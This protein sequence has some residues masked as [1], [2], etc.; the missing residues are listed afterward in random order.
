MMMRKLKALL[1]ITAI[2]GLWIMAGLGRAQVGGDALEKGFVD[3]P[4][5]AKPRVW[6]HWT[7]GNVTKEGITKD[8]EWMKRVGVGGA[9]MADIGMAGGQTIEKKIEFFTPEWFDAIKHAAAESDRL[10]L[11]MSIF[12]SSGWSLTGGPW[13]KPEQAMKKL[14]W[15]ETDIEGPMTF[16]QKLQQPPSANGNF[17]SLRGR[18]TAGEQTAAGAYYGDSI[19]IAF[20]TP[21][22]ETLMEDSKPNVTTSG[23]AINPAPLMDDH[24]ATRA[25]ITAGSDDVAWV[26]YEFPQAINAKAVTLIAAGRGVPFGQI[27]AS[28]DGRSYRTIVELPGAVQYR[29]GGLKTYAFPETTAKFIRLRI[30]GEAPS[31]DAVMYQTAPKAAKQYQIAEFIVHTG[32]RVDRWEEKAGFNLLYDYQAAAPTP[33]FPSESMIQPAEV[34]DLSSKMDKG[35]MLNW[36]V[37][38]GKWTV[39]RMGYSLVGSK[40]RAGTAPGLGLEVDK[41][42][43]KH[44]EAYFHGYMDP[45]E[46]ALGPLMGKSLRYMMMDSW[47]AGMQNW[48]DD[49][50]DQF[51]KRRGYDPKPYLPALTGRVVASADRSDRFLWDF[52]RTIADLVAEAHYG[53]MSALLK[54]K[55]MGIYAEA[56]GVSMEVLEDTLLAK[57]NVEIPMGEFWLGKMHP[58]A[59]YYVDVRMAA[60]AAHAYGKT[61]VAAESFTGGGYDAPVSYKN[62]ADYWFAQGVNRIVIHSSAHQPLDTKPGNTMVGTHFNRNITWAEQAKPVVT[63]LARTSHMLQQGLFV[64][65]FA[66]LLNEG[67]PSSQPFWG[68]GLQPTPPDGYDY[69]T[70]NADVLLNRTTIN[71]DGRLVLPDGMSYRILVLPQTDRMRPELLRKIRDLAAGGAIVVGPKPVMSPSLQRSADDADRE[72]QALAHEVWGDLDGMQRNKHFYGKGLVTWGLPLNEVLSLI[73]LPKDAE[74]AG[75]LDSSTVWIHRRAL[76]MDIYFVANRKDS[77]Q[78]IQ[79]RF[80]VNGK[81]AEL[82]HPD[83]GAI[84]PANFAIADG[85]TTV[86]LN[87]NPRESVFIVFRRTAASLSRPLPAMTYKVLATLSGPWDVAFAPNLGAP[88]K[89]KFAKLESWTANADEGVKYFSGAATYTKTMQVPQDWLVPGV[90]LMLD[91]GIV[92]DIAE[93]SINGKPMSILWKPPYRTDITGALKT[94]MNRL[95][96][97]VTNQWTNRQIGDRAVARDK[98]VLA[99]SSGAMTGLGAIPALSDSGLLGPVI[100]R[101]ALAE[102]AVVPPGTSSP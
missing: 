49:M 97:R 36:D 83:T 93:V 95:E 65:D 1:I 35:G 19:V 18:A 24:I 66:Y 79:S 5:S 99:S 56:T 70:I 69:D 2:V 52:R 98:R 39:L 61:L 101:K 77:P 45:I 50:I 12:S 102:S 20:R 76:D 84:E 85:R 34:I 96:I 30:T 11:E 62:L 38:P 43:A 47:E 15:S 22:D 91:L 59:Q 57:S 86:T 68:A 63:Y 94:G 4:D 6:W 27:Q 74:F 42:N 82:W 13:I 23:G 53:T 51:R 71:N 90:R 55:G 9:Q 80:R 46:K 75:P 21:P 29:A 28:E 26:Q 92:K 14:V 3:P 89:S 100:I 58:P 32:A 44:V 41:L 31:P 8:L 60:S 78:I 25:T 72:V 73:N 87:L 40:N 67:A 88:E 10:G 81:E 33:R 48:T 54:Q 37:P 64:A 16:Q 17:G 7:G